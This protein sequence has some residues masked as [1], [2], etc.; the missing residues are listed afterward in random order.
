VP[1]PANSVANINYTFS[2]DGNNSIVLYNLL[3]TPV[4]TF[5]GLPKAGV[6]HVDISTL[7]GGTYFVKALG[8]EK[9]L[10]AKLEVVR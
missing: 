6:L 9:I 7:P 5:T 4:K 1:N 2:S 3:G 8:K 10:I